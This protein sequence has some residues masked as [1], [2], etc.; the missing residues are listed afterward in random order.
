[1]SI[2]P[3]MLSPD[4]LNPTDE[5]I[6]QML[7]DGRVT[8]PFVAEEQD[9]SLEYVRSRLTRLVEHEHVQRVHDGLYE[10]TDDPREDGDVS[11]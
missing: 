10:L 8:A 9:K 1:M 2:H 3:G 4:Q 7:D 11:D 6:L 5:S